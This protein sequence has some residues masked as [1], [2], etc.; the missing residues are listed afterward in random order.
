MGI[1]RFSIG[2]CGLL[3]LAACATTPGGPDL[4]VG[5]LEV[6]PAQTTAGSPIT[7]NSAIDNAG[8]YATTSPAAMTVDLYVNS[9]AGLP[10][11]SLLAWRQREGE[12]L[13]P[14]ASAADS[15]SLRTPLNLSAGLYSICANVDPDNEIAETD[16]ANNRECAPFEIIPGALR[17]ADLIIEDVNVIGPV[18]ASLKVRVTLKNAGSLPVDAPFRIMAFARNPRTPLLFVDCPITQGQLDAGSPVSCGYVTRETPL[19]PGA[20]AVIDGYFAFA[21]EGAGRYPVNWVGP[22]GGPAPVKRTVDFMVD[23]CFPPYDNS[24]VECAIDEVDELNNF[25]SKTLTT[26]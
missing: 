4:V 25:K 9:L 15:A 13:A 6:S 21:I 7:V 24:R 26:R 18:D 1:W 8:L 23:G 5:A 17:A 16:K 2:C 22:G 10:L 19:S 14:G 3:A 12:T 11:T 20:K